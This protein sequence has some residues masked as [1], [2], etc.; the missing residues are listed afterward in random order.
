VG[1]AAAWRRAQRGWPEDFP[2]VQFPNAPLLVFIGAAVVTW[3]ADGRLHDG[4]W[5]V[6]RVALTIWAYEEITD[7]ANWFRRLIGIAVLAGVTV[8]LAREVG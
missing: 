2:L 7:P 6:S 8:G 1:V 3:V 5:A 4:A